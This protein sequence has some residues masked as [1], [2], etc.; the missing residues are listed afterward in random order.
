MWGPLLGFC[1]RGFIPLCISTQINIRQPLFTSSGET[2]GLVW[3]S[4]LCCIIYIW[5]PLT[6]IYVVS[7]PKAKLLEPKFKQMYGFLFTTIKN[8]TRGQRSY[9]LTFIARR[10]ILIMVALDLENFSGIQVMIMVLM[11]EILIIFTVTTSPII[12]RFDR[13]MDLL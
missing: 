13:R 11:N 6:M 4:L 7:V 5:F 10:F 9:F 8:E 3:A 12:T 2:I 1:Y